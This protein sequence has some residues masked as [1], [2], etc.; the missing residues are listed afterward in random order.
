MDLEKEKLEDANTKAKVAYDKYIA[1]QKQHE[2][3]KLTYAI[4]KDTPV[5]EKPEFHFEIPK[6]APVLEKPEFHFEIPKDAPVLEKPEFHFEIPK[7]APVLE[8]SEFKP[9]FALPHDAP[10]L[11]KPEFDIN[12]LNKPTKP[13]N[14]TNST[15]IVE[16]GT[17]K[18]EKGAILPKTGENSKS[19][20]AVGLMVLVA[21][22]VLNRRKEK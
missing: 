21:S 18:T 8:K 20:V 1:I 10:I 4:T 22:L 6:D 9:G 3:E 12:S 2:L 15:T 19:S 5:L 17:S 16:K 14:S 13:V 7:D 11:E